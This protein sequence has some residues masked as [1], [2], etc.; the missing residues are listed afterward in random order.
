MFLFPFSKV[1]QILPGFTRQMMPYGVFVEF[2]RNIYGLAPNSVSRSS[3]DVD[4]NEI[5]T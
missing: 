5:V 3:V 4:R 2:S 1:G